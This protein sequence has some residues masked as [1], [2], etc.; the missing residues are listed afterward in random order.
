MADK[1]TWHE[2]DEFWND[3]ERALFTEHRTSDAATEV[4]RLIALLRLEPGAAVLDLCCGVGRHTLEFARRGFRV[5]GV[6]RTRAYLDR[7]AARAAEDGLAV[8]FVEADMR[9]FRRPGAYDVVVNLFTS[10]GYF[11]DPDEDRRVLLNVHHSLAEGGVLLMDLMGKEVLARVFVERD[12]RE[13][14]GMLVLEEGKV[15]RDWSWIE[16]R[17]ILI[18]D[19][20][21]TEHRLGLCIY[22]AAE[23]SGLLR[24]CGFGSVVAYGDLTGSPYDLAASRLVMLARK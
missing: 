16:N 4:E 7:A 11:E 10:F 9:E 3:V 21:R 6:D 17:W 18:G 13:E 5:T 19:E 20:R 22:S 2:Q 1:Q 14:D 8:D 23:L 24:D 15:N 12:W